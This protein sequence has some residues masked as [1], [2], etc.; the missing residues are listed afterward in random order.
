MGGTFNIQTSLYLD[1]PK[2]SNFIFKKIAVI[3]PAC[4]I[5]LLVLSAILIFTMKVLLRQKKVSKMKSDSE[6]IIK[7]SFYRKQKTK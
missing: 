1:F 2:R 6:D 4:F 5:L 3:I 7:L